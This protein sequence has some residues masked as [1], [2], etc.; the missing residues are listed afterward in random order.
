MTKKLA[1]PAWI[2]EARKYI[3]TQEVVGPKHN[4]VIVNFWKEINLPYR[5]DEVPWCAGFVDAMLKMSSQKWIG[6]AWARA[7]LKY[8]VKLNKPAYGCIVVFERGNGG[9]VGFVVG[10]DAKG[11]L[12]VLGGNQ[13]N[14]V[15]IK[16]FSVTRVLGY[17]WPSV[18]PLEE[19][20]NL[21][22][23]NSDG[24]LSTN[25]A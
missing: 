3:G 2:T 8:G 11:N 17:R 7:F 5:D 24:K 13:S 14:A 20:F 15:N 1:D 23:L 18:W 25:E 19:R 21:P 10:R 4:N 12:M 22:L 6:T 9:H 16:P